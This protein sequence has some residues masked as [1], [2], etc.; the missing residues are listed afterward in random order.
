M[1]VNGKVIKFYVLNLKGSQRIN[2][3]SLMDQHVPLGHLQRLSALPQP[4]FTSPSP[5]CA[6]VHVR[7]HVRVRA[8]A[9][10]S[11]GTLTNKCQARY[12]RAHG[13]FGICLLDFLSAQSYPRPRL[14]SVQRGEDRSHRGPRRTVVVTG[15]GYEGHPP[16][17]T[18]SAHGAAL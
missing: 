18:N 12:H 10:L 15:L 8:R 5:P 6:R 7:V 1:M 16:K 2:A 13:Y 9:S 11:P 14:A 3:R 4:Y 17:L